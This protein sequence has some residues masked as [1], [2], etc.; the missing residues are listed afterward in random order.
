MLGRRCWGDGCLSK[1]EIFPN[2]LPSGDTLGP[3]ESR[4]ESEAPTGW[5]GRQGDCGEGIAAMTI[6]S[7]TEALRILGAGRSSS[8][9]QRGLQ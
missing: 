8:N 2:E 7:R 4:L 3:R 1:D 6:S 9:V 5:R